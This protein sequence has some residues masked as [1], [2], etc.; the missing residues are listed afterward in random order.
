MNYDYITSKEGY[1]VKDLNEKHQ[2]ELRI[3]YFLYDDFKEDTVQ[4]IMLCHGGVLLVE[5]KMIDKMVLEVC[6]EFKK[7]V[8]DFLLKHIQEFQIAFGDDEGYE[9]ADDEFK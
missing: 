6:E 1:R 7:A 4:N 3:P 5:D 9:K 8:E 2:A